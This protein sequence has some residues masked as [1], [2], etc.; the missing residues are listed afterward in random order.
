MNVFRVVPEV[1]T[2]AA[3]FN[4]WRLLILTSICCALM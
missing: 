4:V 3:C 2:F 1:R